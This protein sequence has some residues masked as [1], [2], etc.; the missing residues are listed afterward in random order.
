MRLQQ[1]NAH[2]ALRQMMQKEVSLRSTQGEAIQ[3]IQDGNSPVVAIMPTG[4]GKS[5]L[6]MLS[7]WAEAGGV[8]VVV[9]LLNGLREDMVFRC[10]KFR[11]RYT[12]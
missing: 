8:T 3:A 5:V 9:V 4:S 10:K 2:A 1:M 11:I 12:V 7:A 6:F